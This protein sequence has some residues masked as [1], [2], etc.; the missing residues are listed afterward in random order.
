MAAAVDDT[1]SLRIAGGGL[2]DPPQVLSI[3]GDPQG[4]FALVQQA[5][6]QSDDA[7]ASAEYRQAIS[8]VLLSRLLQSLGLS[9]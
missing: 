8:Q 6:Q 1:G 3:S 7:W 9:V 4:A 5:Y 2:L